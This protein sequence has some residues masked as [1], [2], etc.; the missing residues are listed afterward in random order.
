M[1]IETKN[2]LAGILVPVFAL[3]HDHDFG[4]GDTKAMRDAIEFCEENNVGVLQ[5]LPINET[6][7]DNSPYNAISSVALD[8][9]YLEL[10]PNAVPGLS[11]ELIEQC[12][13]ASE[14][15][16]LRQ[17]AV[18]YRQVKQLKVKVLRKAFEIFEK[19]EILKS[20]D[21][22]AQLSQFRQE[23][24]RWLEPYTLFRTIMDRH[25]GSSVWTQWQ[26]QMRSYESALKHFEC[27]ADNVDRPEIE[28]SR[29]FWA[30][31]QWIA[32]T[33]WRDLKVFAAKHAVSLM[34]DL[35]FG[36]SR[37]S[38]DV[39]AERRIFDLDW[40][41]GAPPEIYFQGDP[42]V[43]QW[44][45]NWGMPLYNWD[46]NKKED[47]AW[48][49]QRIKHLN[50]LFHYVR[51]DHVLGF[52]RV[53]GFPW[54]PERNDEFSQLTKEQAKKKTGG[55]L[56]HF[57][58]RADD[59]PQDAEE[60][61]KEGAA[62]LQVLLDAAGTTGIV[63]E[64]LGVVPDYVRPLIHEL[65]I[66]GFAIPIFERNEEDRSFKAKETLHELSLATYATHDHQPIKVFYD[67]LVKWWHGPEGR[68]GWLE[69]Q[70]LMHFLGE[71]ET[72]PPTTFSDDLHRS[73]LRNLL[74][75][76][77]WLA[78]VMITDLLGTTQRFNEPG[79]SGDSNWSQRLDR[80][81]K[82]YGED[83]QYGPKIR[84]FGDLIKETGRTPLVSV[85]V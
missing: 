52:F 72:D 36:V 68:E 19:N 32:F 28:R 56:P 69:V 24:S 27:G 63:A 5:I 38:A 74:E 11:Q 1:R 22:A 33:Q 6:G 65:G 70:R 76:P 77:C 13:D 51:I 57:V 29:Q 16:K 53:Y 62:Y 41:C 18:A 46:E 34:G 84:Y 44:G 71:D 40:S 9:A 58:P 14:L 42:F 79:L 10:A 17:D 21:A 4:I 61:A 30:Y 80:P 54:I 47:F 39:W 8:P 45:Q 49:R 73:M 85:R 66:A 35:P 12:I 50:E 2:K 25:E 83:S 15:E 48:W 78:L 43:R 59:D 37:Y 26:E 55:R 82:Q 7:G 81:I 20:T 75:T 3:R 23:N 64:D 31:V 60:N 67:Q